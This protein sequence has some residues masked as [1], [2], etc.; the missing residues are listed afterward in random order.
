MDK[1]NAIKKLKE[2]KHTL[3]R[4]YCIKR[5]GIFGSY[6][7]GEENEKSDIDILVE[8]DSPIDI[9]KFIE[10]EETLSKKLGVKADLVSKQALKPFIGEKILKE[11][12]YV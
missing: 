4:N 2:I 6:I 1:D 11:V 8:F 12:I 10:L 9:F 7:R 5:I 3:Q